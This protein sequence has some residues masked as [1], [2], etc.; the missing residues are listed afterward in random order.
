MLMQADAKRN[1]L[2]LM[3]NVIR[4]KVSGGKGLKWQC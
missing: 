1:W 2:V 4:I 3:T